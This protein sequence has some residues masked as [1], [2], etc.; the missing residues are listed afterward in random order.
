MP[1]LET[2]IA[3][4]GRLALAATFDGLAPMSKN[5]TTATIFPRNSAPEV[6]AGLPKTPEAAI[7][8]VAI[9]AWLSE[10]KTLTRHHLDR[11]AKAAVTFKDVMMA[12]A[13]ISAAAHLFGKEWVKRKHGD[14]SPHLSESGRYAP[15]FTITKVVNRVSV[16]GA[17]AATPLINFGLFNGYK[18]HPIRSLFRL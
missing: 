13:V 6:S 5:S 18:P 14:G 1:L 17:I 10:R 12:G 2:T 7:Y 8:A 4:V 9:A 16:A 3:A 15:Y 11:D